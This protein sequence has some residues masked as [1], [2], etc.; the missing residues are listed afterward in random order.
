[1]STDSCKKIEEG[2]NVSERKIRETCPSFARA[3][4]TSPDQL[5]KYRFLS[6]P[7]VE[8]FNYF[9]TDGLQRAVLDIDPVELDLVD[10]KNAANNNNPSTTVET[11]KFW[12]ENVTI[13]KPT[14]DGFGGGRGTSG[15]Q[16]LY[17]RECR[18]L[19]I[20]YSGVMNG[21]FCYQV[22]HKNL[23]NNNISSS[24]RIVRTQ[25][26]LG[27]IPIMVL[28]KACH[29][30]DK[31]CHQ[32]VSLKE[33]DNEMG[34]YFI[35]NGIERIVR[36]LQVQ[37]RNHPIGLI[38]SSFQK[39]G[40]VYSE[41]G[42]SM[43]CANYCG[44]QTTI[45]NTL[46]Y[47]TTGG[48]TLRFSMRKQ[49]FLVPIILLFRACCSASEDD[50]NNDINRTKVASVTDEEIYNKIVQGDIKNTFLRARAELLLQDARRFGF[51]TPEEA[52]TY[53]GARFRNLTGKPL[54]VSDTDVGHY[55]IRKFIMIHLPIYQDKQESLLL[56]LRKLYALV[57]GTCL[58]D[59]ADSLQNHELLLPGHF[60][61]SFVKEKL[62]E[63]LR[64]V[65]LGI[66]KDIR[67]DFTRAMSDLQTTKYWMKC[68]DRY[69]QL[70]G[71]G[72]GKKVNYLLSTGNVK[73]TTG[74]DLMQASGFTIVADKI[75]F[76]RYL[77][78]FRSVHRGQFFTTMKSTAVRKLLP[79]QWGFL[80][81]V[82][83]PDGSPCGLLSHITRNCSVLSYPEDTAGP[84]LTDLESLLFSLGI[85]PIASK[86]GGQTPLHSHL[87]VCIDGR[88]IGAASAKICKTVSYH[89]REFKVSGTHV[90][91]TLEVAHFPPA[92]GGN[93]PYPGLFLF[94]ESARM[95]RPVLHRATGKVEYIGPMEQP[96]LD[97]ACLP[98]DVREGI[99]K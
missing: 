30:A 63:T 78:H 21:E 46:H 68:L 18:E 94:T 80:C 25:K 22:L 20:M 36:L 54:S 73:S 70:N 34:G 65:Y 47:L 76:L 39:R 99:T 95:I 8:S 5:Q 38:R 82:N 9:L 26:R 69:G 45:T 57:G 71:A 49:E 4:F 27:E 12:L 77:S 50:G 6:E 55:V 64:A 98:T 58:P 53:L 96:F 17:P 29:L 13:S 43:R 56:M 35:V 79:D 37:R 7:H 59:N 33:E 61:T 15:V 90:P 86:E 2:I 40:P 88:M 60:I 97:I 52:L 81:P 3:N 89:L 67:M 93:G 14:K 44:D 74:L 48:V 51:Y 85:S 11:V 83:T 91:P 42:V 92:L 84:G 1:M 62:E 72:V 32:L 75:N 28:S 31:T 23:T 87:C 16:K 24:S 66:S 10:S 41:Y 19:G